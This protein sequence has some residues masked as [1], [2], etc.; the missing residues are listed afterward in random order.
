MEEYIRTFAILYADKQISDS[1]LCYEYY[2]NANTLSRYE[3]IYYIDVEQRCLWTI[4]LTYDEE[5]AKADNV[6]VYRIDLKRNRFH[7]N[8]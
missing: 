8:E 5:S 3:Q 2:N 1:L 6:K 4:M 7:K